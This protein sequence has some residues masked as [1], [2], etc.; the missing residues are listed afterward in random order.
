MKGR[1]LTLPLLIF[2]ALASLGYVKQSNPTDTNREP[3]YPRLPGPAVAHQS[4][5][6]I[7]DDAEV[8][9][10]GKVVKIG[11]PRFNS[12]DN[13]WFETA[14]IYRD[15]TVQVTERYF[16]RL[17]V[18]SEVTIPVIGG[19]IPLPRSVTS[20]AGLPEGLIMGYGPEFPISVGEEVVLF[21]KK[22]PFPMR[23]GNIQ[24]LRV[25]G[26]FQG[27]FRVDDLRAINAEPTRTMPMTELVQLARTR[28][29][30][31]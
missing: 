6:D 15:V 1:K 12:T 20:R 3:L 5:E 10:K 28:G 23:E 9:I 26:G 17:G 14:T 27:K 2:V 25:V 18:P 31:Q 19:E 21:L 22:S 11:E 24:R 4:I 30:G 29:R 13:E 7:I 16:D 8:G